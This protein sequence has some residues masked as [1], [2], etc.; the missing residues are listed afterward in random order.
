MP[1]GHVV[2]P[3]VVPAV[4]YEPALHT[5]FV[6]VFGQLWP[7]GHVSH[8]SSPSPEYSP[9]EHAL[10]DARPMHELPAGHAMHAV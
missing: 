7:A 6:D 2:H 5:F 10:A 1:A 3:P 4:A 8:V 9:L